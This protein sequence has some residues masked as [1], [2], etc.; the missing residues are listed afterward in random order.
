MKKQHL[1][2]AMALLFMPIVS[3]ADGEK[4]SEMISRKVANADVAAGEF[5]ARIPELA[6]KAA[7]SAKYAAIKADQFAFFFVLRDK[8]LSDA[9]F[10]RGKK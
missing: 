10:M 1:I 7:E 2:A 3:V 9:V 8:E 6:D 4:L 5:V